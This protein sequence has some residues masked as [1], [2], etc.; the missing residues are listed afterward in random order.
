MKKKK[1]CFF[2]V[3]EAPAGMPAVLAQYLTE[4]VI[5]YIK[6]STCGNA[7][8]LAQYFFRK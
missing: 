4:K 6:K 8:V 7:A 5:F 1:S 3:E 2:K